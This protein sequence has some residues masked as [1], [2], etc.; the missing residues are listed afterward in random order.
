M[1]HVDQIETL[2]EVSKKHGVSDLLKLSFSIIQD[3]GVG[4]HLEIVQTFPL[5][6]TLYYTVT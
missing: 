2:W 1:L 5:K 6:D 4:I 3:G